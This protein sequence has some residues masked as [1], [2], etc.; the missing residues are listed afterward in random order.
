LTNS[1]SRYALKQLF[2]VLLPIY[3]C[4]IFLDIVAAHTTWTFMTLPEFMQSQLLTITN[5]HK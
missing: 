1:Y 2:A 4:K 3:V 5:D